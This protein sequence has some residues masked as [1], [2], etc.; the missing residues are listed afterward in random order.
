M[1][2]V[3]KEGFPGMKCT[4]YVNPNNRKD[5]LF[6]CVP[7]S[8]QEIENLQG[9][10]VEASVTIPNTVFNDLE[11][12]Q[13]LNLTNDIYNILIHMHSSSKLFAIDNERRGK[14]DVTTAVVGVQ[15]GKF[16]KCQFNIGGLKTFCLI[17]RM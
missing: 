4:W 2:P 1:F 6:A 15:L 12:E 11:E 10:I 7:S 14:E 8:N 5:F 17:I 3:K 9:K 13:R 16:V